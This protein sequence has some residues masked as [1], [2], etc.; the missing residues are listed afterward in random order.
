MAGELTG[1]TFTFKIEVD[2]GEAEAKL[3]QM[4]A[5]LSSLR[6]NAGK[7]INSQVNLTV[8]DKDLQD[9]IKKATQTA[10]QAA[11][12]VQPQ[13]AQ[14]T[15]N[16]KPSS[17]GG[18]NQGGGRPPSGGG[19]G[20]RPPSGGGGGGGGSGFLGSDAR[21]D[22]GGSFLG[23]AKSVAEFTVAATAV[24]GAFS[25]FEKGMGSIIGVQNQLQ[26]LNK[27]INTSQANLEDLKKTAISTGKEFGASTTDVLKSFQ[28]F[29]QQGLPINEVKKY[30]KAVIAAKNVSE[31]DVEELSG[32]FST[33]G[34]TYG[35]DL[36]S[37]PQK[38]TDSLL[39]VEGQ[40]AVSE[41]DLGEVVKRIG[42]QT[43][44]LGVSFDQLNAL[45]TVMK[46]RTRAPAEE[47]ATSLRFITKNL[48]DP[49]I[50]Q[51]VQDIAGTVGEN[52]KFTTSTGDIRGAF[53]IMQDMSKLYP[54]LNNA[55]KI[56]LANTVGETRFLSKFSGLME[57]YGDANRIVGISQNAQG[58]TLK[59]NQIVMQSIGKQA[60][61]TGAAFEGF[62]LSVG[63]GL[64]QP[65]MSALR[66]A[67]KLFNTLE[68]VASIKIPGLSSTPEGGTP[69]QKQGP[70]FGDIAGQVALPLALMAIGKGLG[71]LKTGGGIFGRGAAATGA[72]TAPSSYISGGVSVPYSPFN[73][74]AA[75]RDSRISTA[76]G[77]VGGVSDVL[78]GTAFIGVG[79]KV[80]Q[81]ISTGLIRAAAT[82]FGGA[83]IGRVL[84]GAG[85]AV[86]SL[87]GP[88]GTV[89]GLGAGLAV[90]AAIQTGFSR[91]M[92]TG[93]ERS[94]RQG[95]TD[96][97]V[98][99]SQGIST[100][101]KIAEAASAL[102][103]LNTEIGV[104]ENPATAVAKTAQFL[105]STTPLDDVKSERDNVQKK[106]KDFLFS[107]EKLL[108]ET[109]GV[110]ITKEG[111]INFE[112]QDV[113]SNPKVL[114]KVSQQIKSQQMGTEA[115]YSL[116]E[117]LNTFR[118]VFDSKASDETS[119]LGRFRKA[120]GVASARDFDLS[121]TEG[122]MFEK[123]FGL[124]DQEMIQTELK[125]GEITKEVVKPLITNLNNALRFGKPQDLDKV[126]QNIGTKN[127]A[128][129][130]QLLNLDQ[131]KEVGRDLSILGSS[132]DPMEN[133][134]ARQLLIG[135]A[136][137]RDFD[138]IGRESSKAKD[139]LVGGFNASE[140]T[141]ETIAAALAAAQ[142]GD[143]ISATGKDGELNRGRVFLDTAGRKQVQS[144][145]TDTFNS[146]DTITGDIT[147]GKTAVSPLEKFLDSITGVKI[148]RPDVQKAAPG[149]EPFTKETQRSGFG[150][151]EV[152]EAPGLSLGPARL[153]NLSDI[154]AGTFQ[155]FKSG[156][157]P[158]FNKGMQQ[159]LIQLSRFQKTNESKFK[160]DAAEVDQ[161]T[162]TAKDLKDARTQE[163]GATLIARAI[164]SFG[165]SVKALDSSIQKFQGFQN[166]QAAREASPITSTGPLA[167]FGGEAIPVSI[168]KTQAELSP[169][170]RA[171][172]ETP[173]SFKQLSKLQ[174][175]FAQI[176]ELLEGSF[177]ET[178]TVNQSLRNASTG[179]LKNIDQQALLSMFQ[180]LSDK[181]AISGADNELS[182]SLISQLTKPDNEIKNTG[183]S[184]EDIISELS[185]I[186]LKGQTNF[187]SGLKNA[188]DSAQPMAA[189]LETAI[190]TTAGLES[191]RKG[192]EEAARSLAQLDK[193]G[194]MFNNLD[195][196]LGEG[197][198]GRLG[199]AGQPT[200]FEQRNGEES[201]N[202]IDSSNMNSFEQR[203][204]LIRRLS[205]DEV[206][207]GQK[208]V[209]DQNFTKM[210]PLN[211]EQRRA[212]L[213]AIDIEEERA[214]R[215]QT[216]QLQK[217]QLS[218]RKEATVQAISGIDNILQTSNLTPGAK[219]SL[220]GLKGQLEGIGNKSEKSF[221]T[222]RGDINL[223]PFDI[224]NNLSG[225][226][227]S[228][229][230][231]DQLT[232]EVQNKLQELQ[233]KVGGIGGTGAGGA[234][235]P[236]GPQQII[237]AINT[238][239]PILQQIATNTG[240]AKS[241][242]TIPTTAATGIAVAATA[243]TKEATTGVDSLGAMLNQDPTKSSLLA[244][245]PT[246]SII[247]PL[248]ALSDLSNLNTN[249]DG[250]KFG[251]N[252]VI[253]PSDKGIPGI[254]KMTKPDGSTLYTNVGDRSVPIPGVSKIESEGKL[255]YKSDNS[256]LSKD[257]KTKAES[258]DGSNI[259]EGI[260]SSLNQ[261]SSVLAQAI[262]GA[263]ESGSKSFQQAIEAGAGSLQS[264][265]G[266]LAKSLTNLPKQPSSTNAPGGTPGVGGK[267]ASVEE[268]LEQFITDTARR[269]EDSKIKI[270]ELESEITGL[271]TTVTD[272]QT[273]L[274]QVPNLETIQ[275]YVNQSAQV[276]KELAEKAISSVD[277]INKQLVDLSSQV[278]VVDAKA[279]ST[280]ML[281][282]QARARGR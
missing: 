135:A 159:F 223:K 80:V 117:S 218:R 191:L 91:L 238:Q 255:L 29:A 179:S 207:S 1:K 65:I 192:A 221:L 123:Q 126:L 141:K 8:N 263:L 116:G 43:K 85:A 63:N 281:A 49:K 266:E 62:A 164:E 23:R 176:G 98:N 46:E 169:M 138:D 172:V 12:S 150:A 235:A 28:V 276:T 33:A 239:T 119:G 182:T 252:R 96:S 282:E 72:G 215:A 214:K 68:G 204:D 110:E 152:I 37:N 136:L 247:S 211:D 2:T 168:G 226:I 118:E 147:V 92:E 114:Q 153:S 71:G 253:G 279:D 198:F 275:T 225:S 84:G 178:D 250:A 35:G 216:E 15:S 251:G 148:F 231:K 78:T 122:G 186:L 244:A 203:R 99:A 76:Q 206:R 89:L 57:G 30:G 27:V 163:E 236:A 177:N 106:L 14:A 219:D 111:Q 257:D 156:G 41:K 75:L 60:D 265:I 208:N 139:N 3:Q 200:I 165:R 267:Q 51:E 185:S 45:T 193:L 233:M 259:K 190:A 38:L 56:R 232:P 209:L 183:K 81:S 79:K 149:T 160:P 130:G 224:L 70:S 143:T 256:K 205:S 155:G 246:Q 77:L 97:R 24:R 102:E 83:I 64:T 202:P 261:G 50:Q 107:N 59:R 105:K 95:I 39:A 210:S 234:G 69:G 228:M 26:Q 36:A 134:Q 274:D 227:G 108:R 230:P 254:D 131:S 115:V 104:R 271:S 181:G 4:E 44:A 270:G 9:K 213:R 17:G 140:K 170:E 151:G 242:T 146:P 133:F 260:T 7:Q 132:T 262:A 47:I 249:L 229:I 22:R 42:P 245:A 5:R 86:G 124:Q 18:G 171:Q 272:I 31:F 109:K 240:S 74:K 121:L 120:A 278:R 48:V 137:K 113:L 277:N 73:A 55:S 220:T 6:A 258:A 212:Q 34:K 128:A 103:T 264:A 269:D 268:M 88:A 194:G 154:M 189:Q 248:N 180:G 273:K 166:K 100:A 187:Q 162:N 67:E 16:A 241:G 222:P 93:T 90:S 58:E 53:D 201:F 20:G 175:Q 144:I 54:K 13:V 11:A 158:E 174:F 161:E 21:G 25:A 199:A 82:G 237:T 217:E 19:G 66:A 184:R 61:K 145:T 101:D 195:R 197:P 40:F 112:G 142:E 10:T 52:I 87:A 32:L 127:L 243:T 129:A 167:A 173:N 188:R 280:Q 94:Q 125:T 157:E 196:A